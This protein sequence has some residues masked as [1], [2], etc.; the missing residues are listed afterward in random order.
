MAVKLADNAYGV[1]QLTQEGYNAPF[2]DEGW[3]A[4]ELENIDRRRHR[5]VRT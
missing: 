4:Q 5:V 1:G 3:T 2:L